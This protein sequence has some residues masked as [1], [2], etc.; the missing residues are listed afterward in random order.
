MFAI[1]TVTNKHQNSVEVKHFNPPFEFHEE[2]SI[3]VSFLL[4][5][6]QGSTAFVQSQV[7]LSV[8]PMKNMLP[9]LETADAFL[10]HMIL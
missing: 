10:V 2:L 9:N 3:V 4:I 7:V 5:H 8:S 1:Q 6:G